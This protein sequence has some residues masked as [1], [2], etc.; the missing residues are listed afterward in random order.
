MYNNRGGFAENRSD[1]RRQ[2]SALF[3]PPAPKR[4]VVPVPAPALPVVALPPKK[5]KLTG[6]HLGAKVGSVRDVVLMTKGARGVSAE[7]RL[8]M[9][10]GT[11]M[12]EVLMIEEMHPMGA[13]VGDMV[14]VDTIVAALMKPGAVEEKSTAIVWLT[15]YFRPMSGNEKYQPRPREMKRVKGK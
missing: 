4:D 8:I 11:R 13:Q 14:S 6:K 10:E 5:E 12:L 2:K 1:T 7:F 9:H 15:E 3:S